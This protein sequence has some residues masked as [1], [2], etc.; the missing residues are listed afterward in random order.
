[1]TE[2]R[3]RCIAQFRDAAAE[4]AA[5][6]NAVVGA[7]RAIGSVPVIGHCGERRL[8]GRT[9]AGV[10]SIFAPLPL[11]QQSKHRLC[12]PDNR[13]RTPRASAPVTGA[14]TGSR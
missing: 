13:P 4:A 1:M 3:V 6:V 14:A 12:P 11:E 9:R 2:R 8:V 7:R 5:A 10:C